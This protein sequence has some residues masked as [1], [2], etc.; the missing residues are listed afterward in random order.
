MVLP[1]D[2]KYQVLAI[3]PLRGMYRLLSSSGILVIFPTQRDFICIDLELDGNSS[4]R[5]AS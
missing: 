3:L 1:P 2:E 4:I 5:T